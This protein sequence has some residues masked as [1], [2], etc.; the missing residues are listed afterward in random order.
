RKINNTATVQAFIMKT[1]EAHPRSCAT[2]KAEQCRE[3]GKKFKINY[4]GDLFVSAPGHKSYCAEEK[5]E[6]IVGIHFKH[7]AGGDGIKNLERFGIVLKDG[8]KQ[9][10][11]GFTLQLAHSGIDNHCAPHFR[12]FDEEGI[13]R[14]GCAFCS[15]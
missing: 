7:V 3:T 1:G 14:I 13:A 11:A 8:K 9:L 4:T 5:R 12:K 6:Q 10:G 2:E 15:K